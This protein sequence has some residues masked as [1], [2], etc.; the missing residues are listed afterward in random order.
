MKLF[1]IVILI[2]ILGVHHEPDFKHITRVGSFS[3]HSHCMRWGP[4]GASMCWFSCLN[5]DTSTHV[6]CVLGRQ[7]MVFLLH[8]CD[9]FCIKPF[10]DTGEN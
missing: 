6:A 4:E 10:S 1:E 5:S 8:I 7:E 9:Y 3:L 2:K